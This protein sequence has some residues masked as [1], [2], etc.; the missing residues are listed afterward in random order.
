M[1]NHLYP[2]L[3]DERELD[4]I[5]PGEP[6]GKAR[7]TFDVPMPTIEQV[8]GEIARQLIASQ[9]YQSKAAIFAAVQTSLEETINT[10]VTAKATAVI[11]ELLAKPMQPTDAFGNPAGEPTSL[12]G[13]LAHR[14]S[15]WATEAVDHQGCVGKPD[16]Y[17]RDRYAPRINYLLG[18]IAGGEL[19]K[20]V[21]AEVAK[22]VSKLKADATAVI[23]KQIADKISGAV[24]K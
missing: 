21:D 4:E 7:V 11:E 13:F 24:F 12:Q 1:D 3:D 6:A 2:D 19:R 5:P 14:V 22:I 20:Q 9:G 18:Q 8:T 15:V 10:I 16:H 23:A 17:S